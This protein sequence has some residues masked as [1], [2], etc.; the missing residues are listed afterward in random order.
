MISICMPYY[1]RFDR[2]AESIASMERYYYARDIEIII[3]DDGSP[4]PI[5]EL[6]TIL[7][8]TVIQ[9]PGPKPPRNPCRPINE[10]VTYASSELIVLTSPEIIHEQPALIALEEQFFAQLDF[11]P[12]ID[13]L[14]MAAPCH[15]PD[16]GWLAGPQTP[17]GTGGRAPVPLNAE[18]PFLAMM[19]KTLFNSAGGYDE[20][21][22]NGQGYDDNDFLWRLE[23]AGAIFMRSGMPVTHRHQPTKWNMPSN[24]ALFRQKWGHVYAGS[25]GNMG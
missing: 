7:D 12:D 20:D 2:L 11:V 21:Y 9:L 6:N 25:D 24:E 18:F 14:Y 4:Q 13:K 15:D 5:T 19:T 10:A 16:R 17:H 22:R 1:D 8:V 23:R 3:I